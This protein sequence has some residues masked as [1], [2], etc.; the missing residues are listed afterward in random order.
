MTRVTGAALA[1][2]MGLGA[3]LMYYLDP[4]RGSRR[5]THTRNDIRRASHRVQDAVR[6][7]WQTWR[8]NGPESGSDVRL[9]N[10]RLR[11]ARG[12][13]VRRVAT[14]LAGVA[15]LGVVARAA[16]QAREHE[17]ELRS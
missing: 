16:M 10:E 14:A 5:R 2:G 15:G 7:R 1:A 9:L 13:G 17:F 8:S 12:V 3:G 4:D 6:S 11:S